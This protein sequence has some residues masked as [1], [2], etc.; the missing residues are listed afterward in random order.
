MIAISMWFER[1]E[2]AVPNALCQAG[3]AIGAV[4][5]PIVIAALMG[6]LDTWQHVFWVAGIVG[7]CIGIVWLFVYRTPPEELLAVTV[8]KDKSA[9]EK[10]PKAFKFN[11]LFKKKSMWGGIL[12]RLVSDP[13]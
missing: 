8:N 2:R 12:I 7:I 10:A 13:V 5:A 4:I 1:K 6:L 3:G 11:E 9:L